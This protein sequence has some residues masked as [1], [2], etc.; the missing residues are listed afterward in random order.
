VFS[1]AS[2]YL[3]NHSGAMYFFVNRTVNNAPAMDI[4][5]VNVTAV[6]TT[7]ADVVQNLPGYPQ[8][9]RPGPSGEW[10]FT[11]PSNASTYSDLYFRV[12]ANATGPSGAPNSETTVGSAPVGYVPT[13]RVYLGDC[14]S[15]ASC[16]TDVFTSGE[17]A[18]VEVQS[19][20]YTPNGTGPASGLTAAFRFDS[21][22]TAV[23][24]AGNFPA[25]L[26]TNSSGAAE[27]VFNA[28]ASTFPASQTAT[29]NVT[30]TDSLNAASTYGPVII[31][32]S[33]SPVTPLAP[34]ILVQFASG[35]YFAGDTAVVNWWFG[36][37]NSTSTEGWTIS[38]WSVWLYDPYS[39]GTTLVAW[40]SIDSSTAVSGSFTVA[41]PQ[42][43]GGDLEAQ[44]DAY[45]ATDYTSGYD[46]VS[47]TA[48]VLLV[49]P[50]E[51]Y[52]EPGD[53]VTVSISPQGQVFG[54]ATFYET[55]SASDGV[56]LS[57]GVFSGNQF[58]FS[59]P[60]IL[61]SS[62]IYIYVSA[63]TPSNGVV[64][65]SET[66]IYQGTGLYVVGGVKTVSNY[67]DGT[68][69]P[70]Q[71]IT[72]SYDVYS[73]GHAVLPRTLWIYLYP[74]SV[75]F[76][77][78]SGLVQFQTTSPTG[79]FQYTIP[80][81]TPPGVLQFFLY[82]DDQYCSG[83]CYPGTSFGVSV[84]PNPSVLGYELGAGSGITVGWLILLVII[85]V[86][87]VVLFVVLRRRGGSPGRAS[88]SPYSAY[89][90]SPTPAAA[91]VDST[92]PPGAGGPPP[93][94]Q[95][96]PASDSAGAPPLPQPPSSQ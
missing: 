39:G 27:I 8:S 2:A 14:P 88:V 26:T 55:V 71:T 84:E 73:E 87:A 85:L 7:T 64:A 5:S 92:P 80:S 4:T 11:V 54:S 74:G 66:E 31:S 83:N 38:S 33:V 81:N 9:V 93:A 20:I 60:S 13:P 79:T 50:S 40:Q 75:Y 68:F 67:I 35:Q 45:N 61:T 3:P 19:Y 43:S 70:G 36:G 17:L 28:S 22:V 78:G 89:P 91:T 41:V 76:S 47:V 48:P 18:F 90:S 12:F 21:G 63:Q 51:E 62:T 77:G 96:P 30:L 95:E 37:L 29:V 59:V 52:F 82:V 72:I 65:D 58:A 49:N 1:G 34:G 57:N 56:Q 15:A 53:T 25:T 86:V 44:V 32:F 69:Q 16:E 23:T 6:Y 24:P 10:N 42:A 94:W 46:Q